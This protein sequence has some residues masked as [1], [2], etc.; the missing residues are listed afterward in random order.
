VDFIAVSEESLKER[1]VSCFDLSASRPLGPLPALPLWAKGAALS[2]SAIG[3][4]KGKET[5][6]SRARA[7]DPLRG[8]FVRLFEIGAWIT[9][10][11]STLKRAR[12]LPNPSILE[13][14]DE[15]LAVLFD[16]NSDKV[17]FAESRR[18]CIKELDDSVH[19]SNILC[20]KL[21]LFDPYLHRAMCHATTLRMDTCEVPFHFRAGA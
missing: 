4:R 13:T 8:F 16:D 2:R 11:S 3:G 14:A 7:I 12:R 1:D 9:K 18:W 17:V 15:P 21:D 6:L 5:E 10:A 20:R 19:D